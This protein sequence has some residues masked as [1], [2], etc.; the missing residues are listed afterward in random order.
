MCLCVIMKP[1]YT[2]ENVAGFSSYVSLLLSICGWMNTHSF[3]S[4][5]W[6]IFLIWYIRLVI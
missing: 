3:E 6:I 5:D 2:S 4:F 1:I